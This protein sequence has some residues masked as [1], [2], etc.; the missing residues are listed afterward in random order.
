MNQK[1]I[2]IDPI[3]DS[4][5]RYCLKEAMEITKKKE[6]LIPFTAIG[7]KD[8]LFMEQH[9]QDNEEEIRSSARL[10]VGGARGAEAYGF[11]YDGYINTEDDG[12]IVQKDC[13]IVEGGIPGDKVGHAVG[14][15]Y[16]IDDDE[17]ISFDD[18]LVYVGEVDN[19]MAH[20][21]PIIP[22][23]FKNEPDKKTDADDLQS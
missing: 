19:F 1:V 16:A 6:T 12:E 23:E 5:L 21:D 13:L 2:E 8:K 17:N 4:L 9:D 3:L 10:C 7:V 20:L 18:Q 22:E 14:I 11:C 15:V